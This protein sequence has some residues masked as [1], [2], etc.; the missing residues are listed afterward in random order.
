[1][2]SL[3]L[4]ESKWNLNAEINYNDYEADVILIESKWNL[5]Y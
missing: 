1:M 4:I 3:I 5:N 2:E